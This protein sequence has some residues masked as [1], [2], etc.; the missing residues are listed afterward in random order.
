[1]WPLAVGGWLLDVEAASGGG[2]PF[3]AAA[4]GAFF[5][6][7]AAGLAGDAAGL[8]PASDPSVAL[9]P[10]VLLVLAFAL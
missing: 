7:S 8:L 9:V 2:A 5:L 3:A 6:P 10:E 1:M 4:F